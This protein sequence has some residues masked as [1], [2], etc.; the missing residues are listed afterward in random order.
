[1]KKYIQFIKTKSAIFVTGMVLGSLLILGIRFV[2][3]K[4]LEAIHYHANFAVFINGQMEQFKGMQYYE[5]TEASA[6]TLEPVVSPS[7]RAHMHD[8]VN[9]VVH[10]EDNLVSWGSFIQNLHMGIGDDYIKTADGYFP[11]T[12]QAKLTFILNGKKVDTVV[13]LIIGDK[14]KLLISY[15]NTTNDYLLKQYSTIPA[16]AEKYDTSQDPAGCSGSKVQKYNRY[17]HLF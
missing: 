16:T 10:V 2:T 1:M 9:N 15:G 5:E 3:Y 7:Q 6:C 8:N 14:D 4:P 11:N 13:G 12:D 17:N